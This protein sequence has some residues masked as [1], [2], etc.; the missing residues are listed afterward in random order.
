MESGSNLYEGLNASGP[1]LKPTKQRPN[2]CPAL[3]EGDEGRR[4][5]G[6]DALEGKGPQGVT[7]EAVKQAVGGGCPSSWGR[8]LSV[9]NAIEADTCRQGDS[10]WA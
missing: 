3:K 2:S 9:T 5:G 10:G 1:S 4:G 8:L 6:G 7:P